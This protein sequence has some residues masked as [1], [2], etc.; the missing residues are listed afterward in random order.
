MVIKTMV[1]IS[2]GGNIHSLITIMSEW[3]IVKLI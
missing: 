1:T 3:L 2:I